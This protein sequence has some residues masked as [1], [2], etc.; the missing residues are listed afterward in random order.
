[1]VLAITLSTTAACG[2]TTVSSATTEL[3]VQPTLD[4]TFNAVTTF[5]QTET[6]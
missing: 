3:P 4:L 2:S 6:T 1:M 5:T